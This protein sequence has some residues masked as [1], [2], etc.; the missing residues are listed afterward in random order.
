[1]RKAIVVLA[2]AT[3]SLLGPATRAHDGGR[4][5]LSQR[6]TLPTI[7]P[8]PEF[9]LTSQDGAPVTLQDFRG[10][11]VAVTFIY[12]SCQDTCPLLAAKMAQVQDELGSDFGTRIAFLSITVDPEHDTPDVLKQYASVYEAN[13]AGWIF[14][15]GPAAVVSDIA[16]RYGVV[17]RRTV[18]GNVSHILLTSIIDQRGRLRVQ[19]VGERFDPEEFRRDLVSLL[20]GR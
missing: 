6:H 13:P 3:L 15:T 14:L 16:R 11:V 5:H 1:M 17:A 10:K 4:A 2:I 7:G 12:T 8:A 20:D 9:K 19:Y 18:D